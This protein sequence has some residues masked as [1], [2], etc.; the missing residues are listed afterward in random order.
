MGGEGDG[1]PA[2]ALSLRRLASV[3]GHTHPPRRRPSTT[4]PPPRPS[5]HHGRAVLGLAALGDG[6][7][8]RAGHPGVLPRDRLGQALVLLLLGLVQ[9]LVQF[10]GVQEL[11]EHVGEG[12]LVE[13]V[14][15]VPGQWL[16]APHFPPA[17]LPPLQLWWFL[18]F[19]FF[20][21]Y[22]ILFF[23]LKVCVAGSPKQLLKPHRPHVHVCLVLIVARCKAFHLIVLLRAIF[24]LFCALFFSLHDSDNFL[25][26]FLLLL[27]ALARRRRR[28]GL[29]ARALPLPLLHRQQPVRQ[30]LRIFFKVLLELLP[31]KVK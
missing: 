8:A 7:A 18:L 17:R 30:P 10:G 1:S 21:L 15:E 22:S 29:R 6:R 31:I 14:V 23:L 20:L 26:G 27:L 12:G 5:P 11:L 9:G 19:L 28:R 3:R 16:H 13:M 24:L 4:R 25:V 2:A